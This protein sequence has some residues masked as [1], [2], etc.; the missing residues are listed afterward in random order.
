MWT[1]T[2]PGESDIL[3]PLKHERLVLRDL[4]GEFIVA[5]APPRE[6]WTHSMLCAVAV[7]YEGDTADSGGEAFLGEHVVGCTET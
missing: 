6:G 7:L 4:C 1:D 3:T 5:L 2:L